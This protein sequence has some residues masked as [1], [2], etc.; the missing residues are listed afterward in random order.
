MTEAYQVLTKIYQALSGDPRLSALVEGVYTQ[1]QKP[2]GVKNP[3]LLIFIRDSFESMRTKVLSDV[4]IDFVVWSDEADGDGTKLANIFFYADRLVNDQF[5]SSGSASGRLTRAGMP[6]AGAVYDEQEKEWFKRW[7]YR[8]KVKQLATTTEKT[9]TS[10]AKISIQ[11]N[12]A[13]TSRAR[14]S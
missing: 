3:V 8:A 5:F 6:V 9:Q 1:S 2:K 13:Q 11:V 12:Q 10:R 7:R 4:F 14:I